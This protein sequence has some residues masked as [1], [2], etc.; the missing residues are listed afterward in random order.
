MKTQILRTGC[1]LALLAAFGAAQAQVAGTWS[2]RVGGTHI[3]PQTRSENLTAPSFP[4]TKVDVGSASALTGGIN[5]MLTDHWALDLPV[6]L[7]FKHSFYGDDAIAGVGKLGETKVVPATLF[8]QYRFGEA[9]AAL[10]PYVGLGVTYSKFFKNRSTAALSAI[11]GGTPA[12]PTT[13]SIDNKFGLTPQVGLVWNFTDRMFLD[14]AY[15][16]SFLKTTAHLSSGQSIGMRLNP[17]VVS[18]GIG[19]RF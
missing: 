11:T 7:P 10:R 13:A 15:Y 14:V 6:G 19:W 8:L 12:N 16:K 4:N 17:D 3:K 18:V 1:A 9:N 5:Y 2:V